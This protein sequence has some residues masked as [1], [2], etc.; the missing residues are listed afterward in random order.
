MWIFIMQTRNIAAALASHWLLVLLSLAFCTQDI[1]AQYDEGTVIYSDS[2]DPELHAMLGNYLVEDFDGDGLVDLLMVWESVPSDIGQIGWYKGDGTG[3]FSAQPNLANVEAAQLRNELFCADMNGDNHKDLV[4]QNSDSGFTVFLNDGTGN[5]ASQMENT[6][7]VGE[8]VAADLLEL[9]DLDGDGDMDGIFFAK[10]DSVFW[11]IAGESYYGHCLIGYND[12]TGAFSEYD[13]LDNED[14]EFYII[15]ETGDL[16][17]DGDIDILCSGSGNLQM[18]GGEGATS[19][20]NPFVRFYENLGNG[21]F[22]EKVEIEQ[23]IIDDTDPDYTQ[24]KLQDINDDGDKELLIEYAIRDQCGSELHLIDC[25]FFYKFHVLDYDAAEGEFVVLK[26]FDSWLHGYAMSET[27]WHF[28]QFYQDAF[29]MQFGK[30]NP[31]SY[32]DILSVNVPQGKLQWYHGEGDGA[33]NDTELVHTNSLYSSI[34]PALTAADIDNDGD[35]DVLVLLNDDNLSELSVFTNTSAISVQNLETNADKI[36]ISPNPISDDRAIYLSLPSELK[37][38]NPPYTILNLKGQ[39]I[40]EGRCDESGSIGMGNLS[41]GMYVLQ[42]AAK[43][44]TY[45]GKFLVP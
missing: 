31:D 21:D 14:A 1:A 39:V 17:G 6:S 32:L 12:G 2:A 30:H 4:F 36:S 29:H 34:R 24:I 13:Y 43:D 8:L 37:R 38:S 19:Y 16:D 5:I 28:D 25:I 27:V 10:I 35:E 3:N 7:A 45:T 18:N 33:F 26:E 44:K 41:M 40:Q 22:A 11:G 20:E 15:A 42:V 23:P 9:A